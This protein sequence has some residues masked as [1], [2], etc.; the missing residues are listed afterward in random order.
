M[1]TGIGS[2]S[3]TFSSISLISALD[4]YLP[5]FSSFRSS[6]SFITMPES[7]LAIEYDV[8]AADALDEDGRSRPL[9]RGLTL[10]NFSMLL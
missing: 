8:T 9:I 1:V 6:R 4:V 5:F 7:A 2:V 10:V 3:F